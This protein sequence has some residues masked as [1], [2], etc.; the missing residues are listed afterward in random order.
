[1]VL[2]KTSVTD[3]KE[4]QKDN[5]RNVRLF[6]NT[7]SSLRQVANRSEKKDLILKKEPIVCKL[8]YHRPISL[9]RSQI[10]TYCT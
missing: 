8:F 2:F 3:S 4:T 5:R 7:Y 9:S 1:M 6:T 10:D